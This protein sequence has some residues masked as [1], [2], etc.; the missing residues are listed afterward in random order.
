MD[1]ADPSYYD[2]P[3]DKI[4]IHFLGE[5]VE[6]YHKRLRQGLEEYDIE[7]KIK[8]AEEKERIRRETSLLFAMEHRDKEWFDKVLE[9]VN[10]VDKERNSSGETALLYSIK[11]NNLY[12]YRRLLEKGASLFR[13][14][15]SRDSSLDRILCWKVAGFSN[16]HELQDHFLEFVMLAL[17]HGVTF[18][19]FK[20]RVYCKQCIKYCCWKEE[21]P[22]PFA[23]FTMLPLCVFLSK[24]KVPGD[25]LRILFSFLV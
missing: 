3:E 22:Q 14:S 18:T 16:Q 6:V 19:E 15:H 25:I 20:E 8:E 17:K 11:I 1:P 7:I 9:Q 21:S 24:K 2:D 4:Y 5:E 23:Y 10:D 13:L 12:Y